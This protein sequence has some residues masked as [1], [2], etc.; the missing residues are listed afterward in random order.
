M[1]FKMSGSMPVTAT[2]Y[3]VLFS[4]GVLAKV[5][6]KIIGGEYASEGQ[7]PYMVSFQYGKSHFCGGTIYDERNI[8]TAAHCCSGKIELYC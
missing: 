3:L 8:I 1:L 2:V 7:F 4:Q 6:S 5:D